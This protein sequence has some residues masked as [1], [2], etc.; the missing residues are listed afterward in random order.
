[1][2]ETMVESRDIRVRLRVGHKDWGAGLSAAQVTALRRAMKSFVREPFSR[3]PYVELAYFVLGAP[4]VALGFVFALL[5][6]GEGAA[7][8]VTFVGVIVIALGVRGSRWFGGIERNLVRVFFADDVKDPDPFVHRRGFFGWLQASLRDKVG[9]KTIAYLGVKTIWTAF[10][11]WFAFS[12]WWNVAACIGYPLFERGDRLPAIYGVVYNLFPPGFFSVGESGVVHG[13]FIVA[14]G[15][16]LLFVAPWPMRLAVRVDRLL[17]R[18]F[19]GPDATAARMRDLEAARAQTVDASAA[20]LRRIERDLH[21]GTQAQ[22]VALAMRLGEAKEQLE[23]TA[24][25]DAGLEDVRRLV[26]DAHKGAKEAI[27]ELRDLARGIHPPALDVGL[28]GALTT[29]V[30][31]STVPAELS[32]AITDRPTPAIE[33]IAYFC[34][35]ELLANVA[36]HAGASHAT[37]TCAQSG[38]WLRLV[39]RDDGRGGAE[40]RT[41]ARSGGLSG[42]AERIR[43][44]DGRLDVTSPRGGPTVVTIDLPLHT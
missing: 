7:L 17:V 34:V 30:A 4:L 33:S 12:V 20:L 11:V 36:Q 5:F 9:W 6:L 21:D 27:V 10:N 22:L 13:T 25:S 38:E 26:A 2:T 23:A 16:V 8:A 29:L 41:G 31:R 24:S 28:E 32:V 15:V 37:V 43:A 39:V 44:V 42:L 19:L 18:L 14:T 3:R 1:V 40:F 35:A